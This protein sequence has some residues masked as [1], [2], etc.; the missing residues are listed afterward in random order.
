MSELNSKSP[1]V[2]FEIS[3]NEPNPK[4]RR[5]AQTRGIF[6]QRQETI[7]STAN[8]IPP[9]IRLHERKNI[10]PTYEYV[11]KKCGHEF[12][13]FQNMNDEHLKTCPKCGEDTLR[14]KIG[15]GAGVIFV[16]SGFYCNDYKGK[17]AS[18][19]SG[20]GHHE[21]CCGDCCCHEHGSGK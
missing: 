1:A 11:C 2:S 13:Q 20:N 21:H 14:R 5:W 12:E 19:P 16:G 7:Q 17:N 18:L 3:L 9:I 8:E 4:F 15:S 6:L 10:M